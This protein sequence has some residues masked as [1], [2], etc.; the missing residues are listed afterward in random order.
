MHPMFDQE[1]MQSFH[2][3]ESEVDKKYPVNKNE[4]AKV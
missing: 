1:K 2:L 4:Q 3:E